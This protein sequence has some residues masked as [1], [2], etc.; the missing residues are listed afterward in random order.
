MDVRH[1]LSI[2]WWLRPLIAWTLGHSLVRLSDRYWR[3][4]ALYMSGTASRELQAD[5]RVV[6][7]LEGPRA[8]IAQMLLRA[9]QTAEGHGYNVARSSVS[10]MTLETELKAHAGFF[11]V[12]VENNPD[13]FLDDVWRTKLGG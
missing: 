1:E 4:N 11:G 9:I 6:A 10:G 8:R 3:N 2:D 13:P 12:F 5:L 7:I